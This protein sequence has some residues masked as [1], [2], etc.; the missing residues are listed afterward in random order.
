MTEALTFVILFLMAVCTIAAVIW[1]IYITRLHKERVNSIEP[2]D[3]IKV[4]I[5]QDAVYMYRIGKTNIHRVRIGH[6]VHDVNYKD[7]VKIK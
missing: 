4:E 6:S 2:G 1:A 3:Q 7:I 5:T